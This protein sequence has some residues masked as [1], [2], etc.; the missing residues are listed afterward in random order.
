MATR[1]S[2]TLLD[3]LDGS[4]GDETVP[5]E[6]D[7][8]AYTIDLS[9]A[10][11]ADFRAALTPYVRAANLAAQQ[12]ARGAEPGTARRTRP[13]RSTGRPGASPAG[14]LS[15]AAAQRRAANTA[16]RDWARA[17]G[18]EVRD[19]GRINNTIVEAYHRATRATAGQSS[20]RQR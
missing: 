2:Y 16:I 10:H 11:A 1:T 15:N 14:R 8:T 13:R 3:D 17:A 12:Q 18:Y 6:L 4:P 5:F 7:G 20:S 9:A 19:L